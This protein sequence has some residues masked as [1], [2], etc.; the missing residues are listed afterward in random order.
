MKS[1]CVFLALC[2]TWATSSFGAVPAVQCDIPGEPVQWIADYCMAKIG[3]DDEI[4]ASDCIAKENQKEFRSS[5]NAKGHFKWELCKVLIQSG[6][7]EGSV[8]ACL[9]DPAF[10][11]STVQNGGVGAQQAVPADAPRPAGSGRR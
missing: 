9:N 8:D 3:T 6:A 5:C 7:R 2:T 4:A 10:V 11:G 1:I